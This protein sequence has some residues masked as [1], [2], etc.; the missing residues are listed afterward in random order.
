LDIV[1]FHSVR[2]FGSI[3]YSLFAGDFCDH[4]VHPAPIVVFDVVQVPFFP[5][6]LLAFGLGNGRGGFLLRLVF[7]RP[8]SIN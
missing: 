8:F 2:R 4:D 1:R 5:A 7:M 3:V 6:E